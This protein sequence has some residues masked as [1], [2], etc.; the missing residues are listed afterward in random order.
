MKLNSREKVKGT[1]N[2]FL[3][4]LTLI[5]ALF[6]DALSFKISISHPPS[7]LPRYSLSSLRDT[8]SKDPVIEATSLW[9]Q[10]VV[11]ANELCPW[12]AGVFNQGLLKS[13]AY[14]SN[15]SLSDEDNYRMVHD[16]VI[17]EALALS[18]SNSNNT[19]N[20]S[21][22]S[23]VYTSTLV[24]LPNVTKFNTYLQLVEQIE[25]TLY[26]LKLD[27]ILQIATFHPNYIFDNTTKNDV[28]NYTNRSPYPIIHYLL[29]AQVTKAVES[30]DGKTDI[31]Y[32]NNMNNMNKIGIQ[33]MRQ[34][35]KDIMTDSQNG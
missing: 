8:S 28:T 21:N 11:I 13:V 1:M 16:Y 2:A 12:V 27:T 6:I 25:E 10:R 9:V 7:R 24:I 32:E 4:Y 33:Q 14:Y 34:T 18:Q 30:Y 29:V 23:T 35:L 5:S 20:N 15:I 26:I 22:D 31:I 19:N 3:Y 17:D